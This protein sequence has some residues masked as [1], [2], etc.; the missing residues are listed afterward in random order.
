MSKYV[1]CHF[2]RPNKVPRRMYL[3]TFRNSH[4]ILNEHRQVSN[5]VQ[6]SQDVQACGSFNA[7]PHRFPQGYCNV[8]SIQN[9][10]IVYGHIQYIYIYIYIYINICLYTYV[11]IYMYIHMY[12]YICIHDVY[13]Y[14]YF[15]IYICIYIYIYI[16]LFQ[17]CCSHLRIKILTP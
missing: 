3:I 5:S 13:T 4:E 2:L 6:P 7:I 8:I 16:Y 15:Y 10:H 11:Y 17:V 12:I 1:T 14:I 9:I